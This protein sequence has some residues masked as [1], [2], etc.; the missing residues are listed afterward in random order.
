MTSH[1]TPVLHVVTVYVAEMSRYDFDYEETTD[2]RYELRP[3]GPHLP[4]RGRNGGALP[5]STRSVA[6]VTTG[7]VILATAS[8]VE[9]LLHVL[10]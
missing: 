5:V 1:S 10:I 4:R 7:V 6:L 8:D 9:K 3:Y 2:G